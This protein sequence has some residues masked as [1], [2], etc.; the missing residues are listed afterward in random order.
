MDIDKVEQLLNSLYLALFLLA[1]AQTTYVFVKLR[2]MKIQK[3]QLWSLLLYLFIY[4]VS[5]GQ[6][7]FFF[8]TESN[9]KNNFKIA[10]YVVN[11]CIQIELVLQWILIFLQVIFARSLMLRLKATEFQ[12]F[13]KKKQILQYIKIYVIVASIIEAILAI[14]YITFLN[15]FAE[16]SQNTGGQLNYSDTQ[17]LIVTLLNSFATLF[18]LSVDL[19]MYPTFILVFFYFFKQH[20]LRHQKQNSLGPEP[21]LYRLS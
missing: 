18:S 20:K 16:K 21:D 2:G 4:V 5:I 14:M 9:E 6:S 19:M 1:I 8:S 17:K 12:V 15:F 11:M 10:R 7:I 3:F 13:K